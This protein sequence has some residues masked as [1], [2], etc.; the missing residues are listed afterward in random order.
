MAT[1]AVQNTGAAG[2]NATP[3]TY[4]V[5]ERV[6]CFHGPLVYE[7][8]ILAVEKV[9]DPEKTGKT[10]VHYQVHYKGWKQTWDEL[11]PVTRLLKMNQEGFRIQKEMQ[12][13]HI[14]NPPAGN[15]SSSSTVTK[16]HKSS[17]AKDGASTS[18]A[19]VRKEGRG[20]KRGRDED[21]SRKPELKLNVPEL[22]K[23][24]LVDDWEAV[25]RNNQHVTLPRNPTVNDIL[26][27][28]DEY[29]RTTR[30]PNIR[31][32][33]MLLPSII[34]GLQC[35]FDKA[36]GTNLLYR[37]E[38]LQYSHVRKEYWTG[39]Q[40][41]IGTE[42]EMSFIYGAEHL[43]RMLVN[44]P[45]MISQTS[46]DQESVHVI[47]DYVDE[48]LQYMLRE[49]DR[50]FLKEYENPGPGYQNVSRS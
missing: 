10:G 26:E 20:T 1:P 34:S 17:S 44:L 13:N 48:L 40:V 6:F 35:Y 7:A 25:T 19:G 41:V 47:K 22:L 24:K 5:G 50:I 42:K 37:F 32:P 21:D 43:L 3:E 2:T 4:S 38:R 45:S 15:G 27:E 18:R 28:F 8:K 23:K 49:K 14:A 29:I 9:E 11:V 39:Q 46:L 33:D 36:L 31:D 16:G 30:P 12:L